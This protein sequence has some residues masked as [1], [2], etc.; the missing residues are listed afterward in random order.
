MYFEIFW[1]GKLYVV[2]EYGLREYVDENGLR[3]HE[4]E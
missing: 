2:D 3:E 4:N 1:E